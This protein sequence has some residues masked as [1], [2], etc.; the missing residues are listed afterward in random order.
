MVAWSVC[1]KRIALGGSRNWILLLV[2]FV[3]YTTWRET[4]PDAHS[5]KTITFMAKMKPQGANRPS[6]SIG[7]PKIV[8]DGYQKAILLSYM[9]GGTTFV[10]STFERNK[11][12]FYV[13]EPEW[14]LIFQTMNEYQPLQNVDGTFQDPVWIHDA[15]ETVERLIQNYLYCNIS[16]IDVTSLRQRFMLEARYTKPLYDCVRMKRNKMAN[17]VKNF[18]NVCTSKKFRFLKTVRLRVHAIEKLLTNDPSLRIIHMIRD[19]RG[20]AVSRQGWQEFYQA[21]MTFTFGRV[22]AEMLR[23][24][25]SVEKLPPEVAKRVL[26]VLYEEVA[27]NPES[28]VEHL[29]KFVQMPYTGYVREYVKNV[30]HAAKDNTVGFSTQRAN[31]A[32]TAYSWRAKISWKLSSE[33]DAICE[34]VYKK[35]G[36][37]RAKSEQVLRN[38]NISLRDPHISGSY[39]D[40]FRQFRIPP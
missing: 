28:M 5:L 39:V 35:V 23:D 16:G 10:G 20:I 36:Y 18:T 34:R 22:C 15:D 37:L 21:K 38:Y 2:V 9:R 30:T 26:P 13:F 7:H 3:V 4:F 33:I 14:S 6:Q 24:I 32:K 8:Q 25:E 11:D 12:I 17:C 19:P 1:A 40:K 29:Y 27:E 31:S